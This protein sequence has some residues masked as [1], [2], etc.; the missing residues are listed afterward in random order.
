MKKFFLALWWWFV[1][2]MGSL[3]AYMLYR[4]P[5]SLA[6]Y[7]VL[8]GT[9]FFALCT[10]KLIQEGYRPWG[11]L[12][13][14]RT[15]FWL[16]LLLLPLTLLPLLSAYEVWQQGIYIADESRSHRLFNVLLTWGLELLQKLFGYWGPIVA[17]V[18]TSLCMSSILLFVMGSYRR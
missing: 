7:L 4:K 10:F 1:L 9:A 15:G 14:S 6:P 2:I 11:L 8:A 12:G 13:E 16:S 17:M 5:F 18:L 3:A